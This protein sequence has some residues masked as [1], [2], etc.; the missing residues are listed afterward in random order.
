MTVG[1]IAADVPPDPVLGPDLGPGDDA[2]CRLPATTS[3]D[4]AVLTVR[5]IRV[6]TSSARAP[7]PI[8]RKLPAR[9]KARAKARTNFETALV[10]SRC[11]ITNMS[12]AL[13]FVLLVLLVQLGVPNLA[14]DN[15]GCVILFVGPARKIVYQPS[16]PPREASRRSQ[17]RSILNSTNPHRLP[18]AIS[19]SLWDKGRKSKFSTKS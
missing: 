7:W 15:V 12:L 4:S 13:N 1:R 16:E 2:V 5:T 3:E 9:I 10:I 14:A 6:A 18:V 11:R 17:L 8:S 19:V